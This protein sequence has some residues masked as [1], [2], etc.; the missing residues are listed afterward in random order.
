MPLESPTAPPSLVSFIL[1]VLVS[2][3]GR[4]STAHQPF[5]NEARGR[6]FGVDGCSFVASPNSCSPRGRGGTGSLSLWERVGAKRGF[7]T[8]CGLPA[9]QPGPAS[10]GARCKR[11]WWHVMNLITL[12]RCGCVMRHRLVSTS[13]APGQRGGS[14]SDVEL[15]RRRL[16]HLWM[17]TLFTTTSSPFALSLS[18]G[19]APR[20]ALAS[21]G[22]ARTVCGVA[23]DV[24][25]NRTNP[26]CKP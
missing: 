23:I 24:N 17:F 21:T 12:N 2:E 1:G 14:A 9:L 8:A 19:P 11:G 13:N 16:T 4:L 7:Q 6:A 26:R 5:G 25:L 15:K 3:F 10:P 20:Y 22:S 18:K